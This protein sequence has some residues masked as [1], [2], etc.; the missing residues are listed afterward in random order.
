MR[1]RF[2]R[3]RHDQKCKKMMRFQG[4]QL[5]QKLRDDQKCMKKF[6][7]DMLGKGHI[8]PAIKG[9]HSILDEGTHK[10][11]PLPEGKTTDPKDPK[12]NKQPAHVGFPATHPD[13]GI[14]T[15]LPLPEGIKT[16]PK[17]SER[18]KPLIDLVLS[19]PPVTALS[20]IDAKYQLDSGPLILTTVVNIYALFGASDDELKEYSDDDVFE[21][22]EEMDEDI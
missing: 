7:E 4:M 14:S 3:L 22:E 6:F 15:T 12:G 17:D 5:I 8:Q 2:R 11:K 21:A 20:G 16:D 9:F 19:T 1:S 13:K 18:I 10:S